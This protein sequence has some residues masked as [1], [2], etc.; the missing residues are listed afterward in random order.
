MGL[1]QIKDLLKKFGLVFGERLVEFGC[2]GTRDSI[3]VV[4]ASRFK[5]RLPTYPAKGSNHCS[6]TL[7]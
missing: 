2:E 6:S 7:D 3:W 1:Q 5:S 4:V